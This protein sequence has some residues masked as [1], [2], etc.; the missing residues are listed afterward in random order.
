MAGE[1]LFLGVPVRAFLKGISIGIS[2]LSENWFKPTWGAIIQDS[3]GLNTMRRAEG[4][5][6]PL[7][8]LGRPPCPALDTGALASGP[9]GFLFVWGFF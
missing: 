7:L 1:T 9:G 4:P 3:E 5:L 6:L 8:E 2:R